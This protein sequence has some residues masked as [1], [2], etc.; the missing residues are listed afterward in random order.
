MNVPAPNP[1][2][3]LPERLAA[4][5][6]QPDQML[7]QLASLVVE[8]LVLHG[9]RLAVPI[10]VT[11]GS[12][13]GKTH[14]L[15]ALIQRLRS[16]KGKS[17]EGT[18]RVVDFTSGS[19]ES[20][21][22]AAFFYQ[23]A[24]GLE[25]LHGVENTG[26][27]ALNQSGRRSP[28]ESQVA[29]TFLPI[30]REVADGLDG[31]VV[32][33]IDD[34][35]ELIERLGGTL[36]VQKALKRL[37][38]HTPGWTVFATAKSGRFL[39][40][41]GMGDVREWPVE[42]LWESGTGDIVRRALAES[43]FP[44]PGAWLDAAI[45]V[46][47][48]LGGGSPAAAV[49]L[50]RALAYPGLSRAAGAR[51]GVGESNI[52]EGKMS[53]GDVFLGLLEH[54]G[55][56]F[57]ADFR[58]MRAGEGA[59]VAAISGLRHP[60]DHTLEKVSERLRM[61]VEEVSVYMD[62]L[63]S[64]QRMRVEEDDEE[65]PDG[66]GEGS[67]A[68][69]Y[70]PV[71]PLFDLWLLASAT[72]AGRNTVRDLGTALVAEAAATEERRV[73][74]RAVTAAALA[75]FDERTDSAS[76]TVLAVVEAWGNPAPTVDWLS[77][78][79]GAWV[80]AGTVMEGMQV[81]SGPAAEL[82]RL[83][84]GWHGRTDPVFEWIAPELCLQPHLREL[85]AILTEMAIVRGDVRLMTRA[86]RCHAANGSWDERLGETS[87][88][89][90]RALIAT[91]RAR[92]SLSGMRAAAGGG[93]AANPAGAISVLHETLRFAREAGLV[94]AEAAALHASGLALEAAGDSASALEAYTNASA[95]P[96]AVELSPV[97]V[98]SLRGW[99]RC[100]KH[101]SASPR[102]VRTM[103]DDAAAYAHTAV[104]RDPDA[105]ALTEST[106]AIYA[107]TCRDTKTAAAHHLRALAHDP[108]KISAAARA[109]IAS[110]A[111]GH[112]AKTGRASGA[113]TLLRA[114]IAEAIAAGEA[115]PAA[116]LAQNLRALE[117]AAPPHF[118]DAVSPT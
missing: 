108:T 17:G 105:I 111:A 102:A 85:A 80:A 25:S 117:S 20:A 99:V 18:L 72:P 118:R 93:A 104:A 3:L 115:H 95:H 55:N 10:L 27:T 59:V 77:D 46:L 69:L 49:A 4:R 39:V 89:S 92:L 73:L 106:T 13:S 15:R 78:H 79:P 34:L 94:A 112:L 107:D 40:K 1:E 61:S 67:A 37:L 14:I 44:E 16:G 35:D 12:G 87:F 24:I 100:A 116:V 63:V 66:E 51:G 114:A 113:N 64:A 29:D 22:L 65:E 11:G 7:D 86:A 90:I 88:P 58:A 33:F 41:L 62:A 30:F 60:A 26:L 43:G 50:V 52:E 101:S 47:H 109:S 96:G 23:V 56:A 97:K 70:H 32:L 54:L 9:D 103:L 53:V 91:T 82:T 48:R 57:R 81:F 21:N 98:A 71:D 84:A 75:A 68:A 42:P 28:R 6:I 74:Q 2:L 8:D 19:R 83:R 36:P 5:L 31:R 38:F 110:A 45:T 76:P